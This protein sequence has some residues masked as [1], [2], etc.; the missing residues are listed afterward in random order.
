MCNGEGIRSVAGRLLPVLLVLACVW[1]HGAWAQELGE[2]VLECPCTV[3]TSS[4]T[5]VGVTFG[6][7]NFSEGDQTGPLRVELQSRPLDRSSWWQTRSILTPPRVAADS[8]LEPQ[9]F[10]AGFYGVEADGPYLFRLALYD[11]GF[12]PIDTVYWIAD[13][14]ELESGGG[15]FS[16]VYFDGTPELTI[17]GG[18]A[19]LSLPVIRNPRSAPSLQGL[20]VLLFGSRDRSF[21]G[22]GSV[23]AV[24][25]LNL[26]LAPGEAS[27][28]AEI[29]LTL[30]PDH[31]HHYIQLILQSSFRLLAYQTLTVPEDEELPAQSVATG[32]ASLLVDSDGDG[33]GDVNER[34]MDTDPDD[35][36]STPGKSTIDVL[37]MYSP[38]F[39]ELY[40]GDPTTRIRH[41]MTLTNQIY[42]DSGL[43]M[44]FRLVGMVEAPVDDSSEFNAVP[45]GKALE[46]V[47]Q[48]GA[49]IAVI[50]RPHAG[51]VGVVCGWAYL[52]GYES[53]GAMNFYYDFPP[54]ANVFGDCSG[55]TTGHEIGHVL[56]LGHSYAQEEV[57]TWRWSRGHGR[58]EAARHGHGL[59][60][61]V[62][63]CSVY[64]QVFRP[65]RRLR[66]AA[67]R[68]QYRPGGW[69]GR[70]Q[71]H[72]SGA[73]PVRATSRAEGGLRRGRVRGSGG[74]VS[75][76][77]R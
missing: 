64:A 68:R 1:P 75:G 34:L 59:R 25:N 72:R 36:G 7:R 15:S 52:G 11:D 67:V 12:W 50:Y 44:D 29:T 42:Q 58:V 39:P 24:H 6:I 27:E 35:P 65:R 63:R 3:E 62:R 26:D 49:D 5:S 74:C 37:A 53:Q 41:V 4:L 28:S 22:R 32:D 71:E 16:D 30:A 17:S 47:R 2:V 38:G 48:H 13:P 69:C 8:T 55:L 77:S 61:F 10:T 60:H 14:I 20:R 18:T 54:V 21:R 23:L 45:S 46:L 33:V 70:R 56:G 73:F 76:Q 9:R 31:G 43:N 19:E 40:N 57:G 66:R 51:R